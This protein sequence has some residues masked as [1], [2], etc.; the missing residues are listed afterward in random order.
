M[1]PFGRAQFA[2][3]AGIPSATYA[4]IL[5]AGGLLGFV[6]SCVL[7][8]A[9]IHG[10]V[11]DLNGRRASFADCAATGLK[12]FLPLAAIAILASLGMGIGII[13]LVVPGFILMVAWSVAIPVRVV[14]HKPIF[15]V[16]GR[17]WQLT[18]GYR[19]PIF[20]LLV[21]VAIGSMA[22]QF[23]LI[24]L[25]GI[26]PSPAGG[27]SVI[28]LAA[29]TAVSILVSMFGATMAGVMY[30]ELRATKEGIGPEALAAVFD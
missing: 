1:N 20:G 29:A 27:G 12:S 9:L 3:P 6:F 11:A 14:K 8:A 16:F 24:P 10:T 18:S 30:Y 19:W 2:A 17:S 5:I 23:A 25:R 13:L 4:V 15:E 22:L 7:Q 26:M 28:F 21:I